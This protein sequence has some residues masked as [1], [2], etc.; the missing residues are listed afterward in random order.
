MTTSLLA[1]QLDL[2][3]RF[4]DL[5]I[6]YATEHDLDAF[7]WYMTALR[8]SLG[9]L[10]GN[11]AGAAEDAAAVLRRHNVSPITRMIALQVLGRI[12]ARRGDPQSVELLDEAFRIAVATGEPLRLAPVLIAHAEA[13]WIRNERLRDDVLSA[14]ADA[15]R[16]HNAWEQ[17]ELALWLQRLNQPLPH[18]TSYDVPYGLSLVGAHDA[19]YAA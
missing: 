1:H 3:S 9:L 12:A 18:Q 13:A 7:G 4:A 16:S 10:S 6:S 5:G 14:T 19:A 11:W 17:A 8:S 2:A 15:M